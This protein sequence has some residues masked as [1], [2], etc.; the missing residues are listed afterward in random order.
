[1]GK[2]GALALVCGFLLLSAAYGAD[3]GNKTECVEQ[4]RPA[5][6][7][8]C[9]T[10]FAKNHPDMKKACLDGVQE[11]ADKQC[12]R[13]FDGD[14]CSTCSAECLQQFKHTDQKRTECLRMCFRQPG[15]RD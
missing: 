3:P 13:F 4:L 1:M 14:F 11:E 15:C 8:Q 12:G 9:A 10:L 2:R 5:L 7:L 6:Q